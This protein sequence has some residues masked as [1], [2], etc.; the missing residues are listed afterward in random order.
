MDVLIKGTG[1]DLNFMAVDSTQVV[2]QAQKLH[3]L[4]ITASVALGRLLTAG[5]LLGSQMKN[6]RNKLTLRVN[7]DGPLGSATVV[8][9]QDGKVKGTISSPSQE[10]VKS[11]GK[12]FDIAKAIGKGFL[13]LVKDQG[14]KTPYQGQVRL[15]TSEVAQDIAHLL[16]QSEQVASVVVLGV[17]INEKAEILQAGG[18]IV[19]LTPGAREE[20]IARLEQKMQKFPNLT[21]LMDMGYSID[22]IVAKFVVDEPQILAETPV[23]YRCDCGQ[24]RFKNGIKLLEKEEIAEILAKKGKIRATCQFCGKVYEFGK[25]N[26]GIL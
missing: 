16:Q 7:G 3:N 9:T 14:L 12:G 25:E 6:K 19:Q 22:E 8:A 4:S 11:N 17:L 15:Q 10:V 21:D 20:V 23:E 26:L 2:R 5:L 13:S 1:D 18:F 24:E